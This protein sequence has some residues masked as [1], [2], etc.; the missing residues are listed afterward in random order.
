M[1]SRSVRKAIVETMHLNGSEA[2]RVIGVSKQRVSQLRCEMEEL[3]EKE[4]ISI[5]LG[6]KPKDYSR[7]FTELDRCVSLRVAA[8][9]VGISYTHARALAI[10]AGYVHC[11]QKPKKGA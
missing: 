5:K 3:G 8:K 10:E 2:A 6:R 4:F 11:W 1:E 7:L 9:I